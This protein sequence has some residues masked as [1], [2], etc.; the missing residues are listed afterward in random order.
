M[1]KKYENRENKKGEKRE[2]IHESLG[3]S[4]SVVAKG[5]RPLS[6]FLK[7]PVGVWAA[8]MLS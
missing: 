7:Y 8:R 1:A 5:M 6:F 3:E 2:D 4:G